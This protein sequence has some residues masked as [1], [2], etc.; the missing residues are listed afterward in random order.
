MLVFAESIIWKV[1]ATSSE[2]KMNSRT[3]IEPP[4]PVLQSLPHWECVRHS[5]VRL[6]HSKEPSSSR[7]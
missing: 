1:A 7:I 3:V 4:Q 2:G 6:I 5:L